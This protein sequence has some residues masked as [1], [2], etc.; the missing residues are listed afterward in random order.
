MIVVIILIEDLLL[1]SHFNVD[2]FDC[3][4]RKFN[5]FFLEVKFRHLGFYE[6]E[7]Q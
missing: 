4:E 6:G 1:N 5:V 7:I 2:R 3:D